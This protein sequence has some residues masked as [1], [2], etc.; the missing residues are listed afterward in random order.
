[1]AII[2]IAFGYQFHISF[3][4]ELKNGEHCFYSTCKYNAPGRRVEWRNKGG[5]IS[6]YVYDD[7]NMI[8]EYDGSNN[9]VNP[10][11]PDLRI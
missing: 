5:N 1:M 4:V 8:A 3:F 11:N 9:K 2:H 7:H 10:V 6:R